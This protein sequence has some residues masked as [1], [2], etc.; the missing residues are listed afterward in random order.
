M[1]P[2]LSSQDFLVSLLAHFLEAVDT[3]TAK[4]GNTPCPFLDRNLSISLRRLFN[5]DEH[6][7]PFP[8][9]AFCSIS[10]QVFSVPHARVW[11]TVKTDKITGQ[12]EITKQN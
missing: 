5:I 4:K 3:E 11:G 7:G 8:I 6:S 2:F 9:T 1:N 10:P 12:F